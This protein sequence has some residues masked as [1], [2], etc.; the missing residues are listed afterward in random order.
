M[1]FTG[2]SNTGIYCDILG[3]V[4]G[5]LAAGVALCKAFG[6]RLPGGGLLLY[7]RVVAGF[8]PCRVAIPMG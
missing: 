8:A 4:S 3:Q 7:A 2:G 6:A 1:D 5:R